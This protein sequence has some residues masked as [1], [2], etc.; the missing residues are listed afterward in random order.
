MYQDDS[1]WTLRIKLA[2]LFTCEGDNDPLVIPKTFNNSRVGSS[3]SSY[4]VDTFLRNL[5]AIKNN[6]SSK[7]YSFAIQDF[8]TGL[9]L[10]IL[11]NQMTPQER[12]SYVEVK[13][14]F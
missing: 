9:H 6:I 3:H 2:K 8:K 4:V 14:I 12:I 13:C 7:Q 10:M 1:N 5:R 11:F